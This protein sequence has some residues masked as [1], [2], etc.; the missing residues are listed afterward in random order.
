MVLY[1]GVQKEVEQSNQKKAS[2]SKKF[3]QYNRGVARKVSEIRQESEAEQSG[4]KDIGKKYGNGNKRKYKSEMI[5]QRDRI[6][7]LFYSC[8]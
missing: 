8:V 4:K 1:R 5:G 7:K 6:S 2:R 3:P